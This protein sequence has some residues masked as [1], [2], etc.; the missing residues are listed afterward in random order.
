MFPISP[1]NA[2]SAFDDHDATFNLRR[3]ASRMDVQRHRL[4][5]KRRDYMH[6]DVG[7]Q[8]FKARIDR[9]SHPRAIVRS[10]RA[11]FA[12]ALIAAGERIGQKPAAEPEPVPS[13]QSVAEPAD[14][15]VIA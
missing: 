4:E 5:D 10:V 3:Q 12:N 1:L 15:A 2:P 9:K 7:A 14:T 11:S 8:K 6:T 13:R